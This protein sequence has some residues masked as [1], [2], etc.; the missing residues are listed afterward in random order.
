[1]SILRYDSF[2]KF[3]RA[4]RADLLDDRQSTTTVILGVVYHQ[5]Y[6]GAER[7]PR[8]GLPQ[9]SRKGARHYVVL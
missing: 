6:I 7:M 8:C 4:D 9:M 3:W 1:M 2:W 5:M